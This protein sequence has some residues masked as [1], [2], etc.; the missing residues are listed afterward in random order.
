MSLSTLELVRV[1]AL[2]LD[3]DRS[4]EKFVDELMAHRFQIPDV[5]SGPVFDGSGNQRGQSVYYG[6]EGVDSEFCIML[7]HY[8][9]EHMKGKTLV[10]SSFKKSV[11]SVI[12]SRVYDVYGSACQSI[13]LPFIPCIKGLGTV[14]RKRK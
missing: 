9:V 11:V 1:V 3:K 5:S 6:W 4:Y 13:K 8:S 10:L 12:Y 7:I 2:V 14:L